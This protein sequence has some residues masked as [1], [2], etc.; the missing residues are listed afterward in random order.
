MKIEIEDIDSC[1]K[2]IKFDIAHADYKEKVNNYYR[3]LGRDMTVPGFRK[4]KVPISL[5]EQ[6]FGPEVK[7]EVLTELISERI[8]DAIQEKGLNAVTAPSLLEV[9]AEEGTDISVS[10]SVEVLPDFQI[11]DYGAIELSLKV[12]QVTDEEVDQTIESYR[13][14]QAKTLPITDR[15]VQDKDIIEIDFKGTCD[16]EPFE[17]GEMKNHSTRLGSKMLLE[18]LEKQLIGMKLG[19]EKDISAKLPETFAN[20]KIAGKD[21]VFHVTLNAIFEQELPALDDDF[22]KKADPRKNYES[23]ADMKTRI[24]EELQGYEKTESRKGGKKELA[25]KITEMNPIEIPGGLLDEQIKFMVKEANKKEPGL[26]KDHDHGHDHDH[27]HDHDH[28]HNLAPSEE[29]RT[30]YRDAALKIL[31]QEFLMDR[32]GNDLKIEVSENELNAEINNFAKMLGGGDA[33]KMRKEW[34][35]N[36]TLSRLHN[37]MRRDRILD[38]VLDKVKIKEEIVDRKDI[39]ADN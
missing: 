31:R 2:Q 14:R 26:K 24:R 6:R 28:E 10:A 3:K 7:R 20:K 16:G 5:L 8:A 30:K 32:I 23:M 33:K 17:G 12:A 27:D 35:E 4:G 9:Q 18:E 13:Q 29:E 21:V 11:S 34:A 1:K 36:G 19:E 25:D 39:I 22:A 15:P 38:A 37:R